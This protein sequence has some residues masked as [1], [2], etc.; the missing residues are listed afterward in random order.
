MCFFQLCNYCEYFGESGIVSHK[1]DVTGICIL[2]L[3]IALLSFNE[4]ENAFIIFSI[5]F[6]FCSSESHIC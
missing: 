1:W 2:E 6:R 3:M 4:H 5:E